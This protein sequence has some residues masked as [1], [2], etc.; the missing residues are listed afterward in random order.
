M[1]FARTKQIER[2]TVDI[3]FVIN[4]AVSICRKTFDRKI[5]IIV[6]SYD[7]LP[8]VLGDSGELQ[9]VFL[10]L[11][12]NAR[13]ALEEVD[14]RLPNIRIKVSTVSFDTDN[15]MTLPEARPGQYIRVSV[16]D[17]GVGMSKDIQ[18]RIF[19]PFFT[20]KKVGKGTGLGLATVYAILKRHNGWI[21]CQ[22]QHGVGTTFNVYLPAIE[23]AIA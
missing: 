5:E 6:E 4:D 19:E 22:S 20:T 8:S 2:N 12:L 7:N 23:Q 21:D 17:N 3:N 9:Q 10:N 13:D 18:E 15:C 14:P 11:C 16:S 1:L